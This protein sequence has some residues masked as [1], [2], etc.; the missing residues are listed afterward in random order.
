MANRWASV[1]DRAHGSQLHPRLISFP[2]SQSRGICM[3]GQ[4]R[5]YFRYI[6]AA[7]VGLMSATFYFVG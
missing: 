4:E 3:F 2:G 7:L 5:S 6:V 1:C